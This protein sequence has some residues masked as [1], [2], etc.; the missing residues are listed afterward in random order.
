MDAGGMTSV[1]AIGPDGKAGGRLGGVL[2]AVTLAQI[3][4]IDAG[5]V[6]KPDQSLLDAV[7]AGAVGTV[8]GLDQD[9]DQH[10]LPDIDVDGDGIEAFWQANPPADGSSPHVDTCRDG[11]GTI[12]TG[13]DCPLAKDAKGNYRFVDGLSAALKF[14]AVPAKL[15]KVVAK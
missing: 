2:S 6:I 4:G 13:T 8:L 3:K 7:F 11:D 15:G 12:I 10:Y 9:K 14:T 1:P 5:G